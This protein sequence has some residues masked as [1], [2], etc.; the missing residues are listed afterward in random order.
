MSDSPNSTC[1]IFAKSKVVGKKAHLEYLWHVL[2]RCFWCSHLRDWKP[3]REGKLRP[4]APS[5]TSVLVMWYSVHY[6]KLSTIHPH[7][8]ESLPCSHPSPH[9]QLVGRVVQ[10]SPMP[11]P[12]PRPT[13]VILL[14]KTRQH[15]V[16]PAVLT[17]TFE[18]KSK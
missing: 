9:T 5:E 11:L 3:R 18:T 4:D 6:C 17:L 14:R 7:P 1:A 10:A 12:P 15:G 8:Q 13:A 16:S 2:E